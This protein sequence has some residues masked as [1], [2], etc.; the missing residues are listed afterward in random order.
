MTAIIFRLTVTQLLRQRRTLLLWLLAA[1]PVL[2]SVLFRVTGGSHDENS[3][4]II[5]VLAHFVVGLILPL[6]ALVVGTASLGQELEDGT[7]VYLVAKPI[8]RYRV[9]LAKIAAAWAVTSLVVLL[10]ILVAGSIV[11]VGHEDVRL[12]PS[13]MLGAAL[14]ALA[15]SSLFVA[16]S[17]GFGRALII[18]LAYVFIWETVVAPLMPGARLLSV[19][20]YTIGI[21]EPLAKT[22]SNLIEAPFSLPVATGLLL[23][24][25]ALTTGYAIRRLDRYQISER[26]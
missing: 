14:G 15:Y 3:N 24:A 18:G 2:I 21:I 5:G 20:A 16:L 1:L 11:L 25:V 9:V 10:A 13:F 6:T 12:L 8:P 19:G 26:V 4:F 22:G 23:A 17:A 7:V